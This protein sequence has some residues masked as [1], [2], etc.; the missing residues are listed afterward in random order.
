MSATSEALLESIQELEKQIALVKATNGET[1]KLENQLSELKKK[2]VSAL[3]VLN[4][5]KQILR[6]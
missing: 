2:H 4:E 3:N 1:S 5:N 6:G